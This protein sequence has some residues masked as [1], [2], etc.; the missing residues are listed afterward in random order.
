MLQ[1]VDGFTCSVNEE[2][3]NIVIHFKQTEPV[4]DEESG[5]V[6]TIT[7]N[8]ASIIMDSDCAQGLVNSLAGFLQAKEDITDK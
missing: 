1:Y 2:K 4:I 3:S 8:I 7:N 6:S 5:D